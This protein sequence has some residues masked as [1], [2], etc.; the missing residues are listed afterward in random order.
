MM[1]DK[2]PPHLI[3]VKQAFKYL[4]SLVKMCRCS[5]AESFGIDY[6]IDVSHR[7]RL[8][9]NLNIQANKH[10]NRVVYLTFSQHI[11]LIVVNKTSSYAG[12]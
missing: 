3:K 6:F 5:E 9:F 8:N 11:N 7:S 4:L 1:F 2:R 12:F 10:I